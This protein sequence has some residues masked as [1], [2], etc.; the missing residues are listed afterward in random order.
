MTPDL[1]HFTKKKLSAILHNVMKEWESKWT[2][3]TELDTLNEFYGEIIGRLWEKSLIYC[4]SLCPPAD[5]CSAEEVVAAII[6][7][8][9]KK[10]SIKF[11]GS[12]FVLPLPNH[13]YEVKKIGGRFNARPEYGRFSY[14]DYS[15]QWISMDK[16]AFAEFIFEFDAILPAV[17]ER[18]SQCIAPWMPHIQRQCKIAEEIKILAARYLKDDGFEYKI[19]VFTNGNP[20]IRFSKERILPLTQ[21]INPEEMKEVF[22]KIPELMR[23]RPV[24]KNY[25]MSGRNSGSVTAFIDWKSIPKE[26]RK[27]LIEYF[28]KDN[29][30][31]HSRISNLDRET[32]EAGTIRI[33]FD[34]D[35]FD[36]VHMFWDIERKFSNL[37]V[38][39]MVVLAERFY[40]FKP[41]ILYTNDSEGKYFQVDDRAV[42]IIK[43]FH[44][45]RQDCD[46]DKSNDFFE[47]VWNGIEFPDI[48]EDE[49]TIITV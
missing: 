31:T 44:E 17:K 19:E 15:S 45:I 32:T 35:E 3:I 38:W 16:D 5:C 25:F 27:E 43:D 36:W 47:L 1:K 10:G 8:G 2:S 37:K 13:T 46:V 41:R 42:K 18:V 29:S 28:T 9:L 12:S 4:K 22:S 21:V 6:R 23:K 20:R 34:F 39:Y 49:G 48:D 40:S 7:K 14:Q 26:K 33:H 11:R 24:C 30:H